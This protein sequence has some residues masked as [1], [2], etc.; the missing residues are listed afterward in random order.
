MAIRAVVFDIGGILEIIPGGDDP[1]SR[2]PEMMSRWAARLSMEPEECN[3]RIT[4]LDGQLRGMGKNGGD[5]TLS[6]A[7]W[8]AELRSVLG[9]SELLEATCIRDFWDTYCGN[10]NLELAAYLKSLRPR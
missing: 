10:L 2:F 3:T 9:W 1:T 6:E 5:G 7:E 4:T 8:R